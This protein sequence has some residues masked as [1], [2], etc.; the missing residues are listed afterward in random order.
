MEKYSG[1]SGSDGLSGGNEGNLIIGLSGNDTINGRGGNDVLIGGGGGR[2]ALDLDNIAISENFSG[3]VTFEGETAGFKNAIGM[4]R[5]GADGTV[6]GVE[7]L[8]ANASLKGSG[9]ELIAGVSG[10]DVKFAAGE[11]IGFFLVPNA[12]ANASNAKL[13]QAAASGGQFALVDANGNPGNVNSGSPMGL[14]WTDPAGVGHKITG[15]YGHEVFTSASGSSASLNSDKLV[16]AKGTVDVASGT[17][18]IGFEDLKGGGDR[19]YDDSVFTLNIGQANAALMVEGSGKPSASGDDDTIRGGAGNDTILGMAGN[20]RLFGGRG[21][22]VLYGNS[23]NDLLN[24]GA[25]NDRLHGG[26][27]DDRVLGGAGDDLLHGD[28]GNDKL[29]GGAGNDQVH[30]GEGNDVLLGAAG[31]DTLHGGVGDDRLNGGVGNDQLHGESGNDRLHGGKGDDE[32]YGDSGNDV[33]VGGEGNDLLDGGSGNDVIHDG[34]GD[35]KAFGGDGNDRFVAGSGSDSYVGG[36]GTDTLVL[37]RAAEGVKVDLHAKTVDAGDLGMKTVDG[38]ENVVGSKHDDWFL[39]D[40][41]ANAFVG[42]AGDDWFR[43]KEGADVFTGGAGSDTYVWFA[44]DIVDEK[45]QHHGVDTIRDFRKGDVLDF[46]KLLDG[47][48]GEDLSSLVRVDSV[49]GGTMVSVDLG[50]SHGFAEVVFLSG[51]SGLDVDVLFDQGG[52]VA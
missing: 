34:A 21:E 17:V 42:G 3:R 4:Y 1:T 25:D 49:K 18:R 30:G 12:Y 5:I 15:Q 40:K 52:L 41:R 35:D 47:R 33:L 23:G 44:K 32:L 26:K 8:F 2:H 37:N 48:E 36:S 50:G 6:S 45:G 46:S 27:G 38:I 22:D 14:V 31:D 29:N 20:D 43:G 28:S 13:F 7:I 24:G 10:L 51:V 16:H 11:R 39:G 9:G 19:D